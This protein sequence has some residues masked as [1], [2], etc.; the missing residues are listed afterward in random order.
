MVTIL[1]AE[2]DENVRLL[3]SHRLKAHFAVLTA[4]DGRE[5]LDLIESQH[6]DLLVADIMM[7]RMDGFELVQNLRRRSVDIPVLMLTA[8]QSFDA[9]RVGFRSGTDDYLTKP[10]NDEEL[11]WRIQALL[12]RARV[13]A[14]ERIELDGIVLDSTTY[15]ISHGGLR[16]ELP[17]KEFDLL[18]K[19]LSSPGRIFTK[20]Q[21]MEE[22]WGSDS[23]S[24]EETIKTH[25]SR[26]RCR[27]KDFDR[28]EI[29]AVK[30]I[31]YKAEVGGSGA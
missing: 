7:P 4:R 9:K 19:L 21:L 14:A 26:L 25:V 3:L 22:V 15:T 31:G 30:G 1:V 24:G 16:V 11:L 28:I 10:V 12:R 13:F 23:D 17:R 29:V 6:V 5:A 8:N 27:I 2:D 20:D 18:F